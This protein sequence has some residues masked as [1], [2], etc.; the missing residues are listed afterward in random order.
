[1]LAVISYE[2]LVRI[3]LGPI[4]VSPHGIMT[5]VGL[6][7]GARLMLPAAARRG[8]TGDQVA[9]VL[10]WAVAGGIVGA[11]LAYVLNHFGAYVE[12]PVAILKVWE[13]GLSLLGGLAGG[14]AAGYP[15][16][17]RLRIPVWRFADA[18]APGLALGIGVGR[19]GDL[20]IADHLGKAT[21][22]FLGY[23]C[24][25]SRTG[26]PCAA[27]VGDA[28]HQTALYDMVGAL[29]VFGLLVWLARRARPEGSLMLVFA[30]S[31][32]AVRFVEGFFRL[33]VTHATGL[34]GS[35]WTALIAVIAATAGL[36]RIR[37]RAGSTAERIS[38]HTVGSID[39]D[40]GI[41]GAAFESDGPA[42]GTKT[43]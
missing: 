4:E 16:L 7:V 34:N 41:V 22:F 25:A 5:A 23:T 31:Y 9:D 13:G 26:S 39:D 43:S 38:D 37:H 15:L 1:M 6:L 11:R 33:D 10:T 42:A 24:P 32:G 14:V 3:D 20:I 18:A 8:I 12:D 19:V 27:P 28:V 21:T 30:V 2:P 36:I 35:Q 17:R 40:T 29:A